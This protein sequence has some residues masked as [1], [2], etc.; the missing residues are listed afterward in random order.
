MQTFTR[1]MFV[2]LII[3][4]VSVALLPLA[5]TSWADGIRTSA[6]QR[7]MREGSAQDAA[8]AI[9]FPVRLLAGLLK[10]MISILIPG[11]IAYN[12]LKVVKK[13]SSQRV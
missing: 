8:T 11:W 1:S 9:P 10:P 5:Q 6:S 13:R 4:L 12:I 2:L 7:T 3:V